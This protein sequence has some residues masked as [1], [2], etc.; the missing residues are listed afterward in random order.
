MSSTNSVWSV[1][2][3]RI[4]KPSFYTS[5]TVT[6]QVG[7]PSSPSPE[8]S[9]VEFHVHADLLSEASP[10]FSAAFTL[11]QGRDAAKQ[12]GF[13]EAASRVMKLPEDRPEDVDFLLKYLYRRS[14]ISGDSPKILLQHDALESQLNE[15]CWYQ[16]VKLWNKNRGTGKSGSEKP[17]PEKAEATESTVAAD[18]ESTAAVSDFPIQPKKLERPKPPMLGPL[19]RLY[20]LADKYDVQAGLRAA[21][22]CYTKKV[23][24]DVRCVP[25]REDVELLW[26]DCMEDAQ[27]PGLKRTVI[28]L[29]KGLKTDS[30][31][32]IVGKGD[33]QHPVFL[34]DLARAALFPE[35][36]TGSDVVPK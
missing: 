36:K 16:N 6:L 18:V 28:E 19:I 30:F 9:P 5:A 29:Y 15:N 12:A 26:E 8:Q 34:R 25:N 11:S 27:E 20:I 3:N 21:I 7:G 14:T 32:K 33:Q 23:C 4:T 35:V 22:C 17:G 13:E 24:R 31:D 1:Q 10:F 2:K